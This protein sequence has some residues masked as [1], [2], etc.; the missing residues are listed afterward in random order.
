[1]GLAKGNGLL[2]TALLGTGVLAVP[3]LAA[4]VA[5]NNSLWAW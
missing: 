2:L 5:G 3:A 4:L 1:M